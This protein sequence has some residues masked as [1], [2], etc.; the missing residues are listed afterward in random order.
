MC[1]NRRIVLKKFYNVHTIVYYI[2]IKRLNQCTTQHGWISIPFCWVKEAR[3]KET[4]TVWFHLYELL[5]KTNPTCSNRKQ[6][7]GFL[8]LEV[9]LTERIQEKFARWWKYSTFWLQWYLYGYTH[10]L[11]LMNC[12]LNFLFY[13]TYISQDW[14]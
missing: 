4:H 12:T 2:A 8:G 10:F 6:I 9:V 11:K 3:Q 14:L 7:S 1:I 5:K 13:A